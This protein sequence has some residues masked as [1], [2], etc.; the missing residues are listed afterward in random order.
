[1]LI[2]LCYSCPVKAQVTFG[3]KGGPNLSYMSIEKGINYSFHAG[4]FSEM[5]LNDFFFL[6]PELLYSGKGTTP[7]YMSAY[8]LECKLQYISMPVL[9]GWNVTDHL[10]ILSGPELN[11]LLEGSSFT[12]DDTKSVSAENFASWDLAMDFGLTY[13]ISKKFKVEVRYSLGLVDV[14]D[15][16]FSDIFDRPA[17]SAEEGKNRTLQMSVGCVIGEISKVKGL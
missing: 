11:Y 5:A 12:Y 4:A 16:M 1:M 10:A 14:I 3:L 17:G 13:R 6:Q 7:R 9:V 15:I 8:D 2:F